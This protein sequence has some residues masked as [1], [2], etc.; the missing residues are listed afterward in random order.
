MQPTAT[1]SAIVAYT[2]WQHGISPAIAAAACHQQGCAS[3]AV[4]IAA[5]HL[6]C[7]TFPDM[8]V[9]FAAHAE[10]PLPLHPPS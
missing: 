1:A 6:Q 3:P 4:A 5:H 8:A 10:P 9:A 2:N 7:S